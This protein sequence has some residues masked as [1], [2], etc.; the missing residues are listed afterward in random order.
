[1]T[2]KTKAATTATPASLP[3]SS[4]RTQPHKFQFREQETIEAHVQDLV[5]ALK[6]GD[7]LDPMTVWQR[8]DDDYVVVDGHHRLEA[9]RRCDFSED[10]PV[11]LHQCPEAD[12][13]LL[14]LAE[15]TKTKLPMTKTE[16]ENAAWRIVCSDHGLSKAQTVKATGISDGTVGKM[17]RTLKLLQDEDLQVPDTWWQ[18]MREVKKLDGNEWNEGMH[19][20]MIL[21]RANALDS[22]IGKE[23]GRA[24]ARNYEALAIVLERRLSKRNLH[25][26]I[27]ML[28][29]D[30]EDDVY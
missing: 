10:V 2:S 9:Y 23:I 21:A 8:T 26:L 17:R 6:A 24:G 25:Y 14:A 15:N 11:T 20:Q 7:T 1:M 30:E 29:D 4:L 5:A 19:D 22:A 28:S 27:D 3:L 16:R 12:A 13:I 18:A